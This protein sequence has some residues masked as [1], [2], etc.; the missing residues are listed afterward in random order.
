MSVIVLLKN[1]IEEFYKKHYFIID[2]ILKFCFS[3]A[4]LFVINQIIGY[5]PLLSKWYLVVLISAISMFLPATFLLLTIMLYAIINIYYISIPLAA[6]VGVLIAIMYLL[7]LR[8]EPEHAYLIVTMIILFYFKL[9]FIVPLLLGVFMTPLATVSMCCGILSYHIF[10]SVSITITQSIG[11]DLLFN[12]TLEQIFS[13][14]AMYGEFLVFILVALIV[15][16]IRTSGINHAF[17]IAVF[18][19]GFLELTL[20]YIMNFVLQSNEHI[21]ALFIRVLISVVIAYIVI[22]FRFPFNYLQVEKMQFEDDDYYYY[23]KAVPKLKINLAER[24]ILRYNARKNTTTGTKKSV[25]KLEKELKKVSEEN[26]DD[27]SEDLKNSLE[28]LENGFDALDE[29]KNSDENI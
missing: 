29:D 7:Y 2:L 25:E 17:N 28:A 12:Q 5:N 13:N 4:G 19:G 14:K 23:V 8:F 3:C 6:M 21:Y 1:T 16:F 9:E 24:N 10:D 27:N 11:G 15:Y 20:M 26:L 18:A 22:L